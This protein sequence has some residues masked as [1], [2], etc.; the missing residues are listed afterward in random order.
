M[1]PYSA[2]LELVGQEYLILSYTGNTCLTIKN[3]E[4]QDRYV[5]LQWT[6]DHWLII[7]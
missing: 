1:I 7:S 3:F 5:L 4:G 6:G 2:I